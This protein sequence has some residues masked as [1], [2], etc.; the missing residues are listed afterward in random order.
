LRVQVL[1]CAEGNDD[2]YGGH[3]GTE[4]TVLDLGVGVLHAEASLPP[5]HGNGS[6]GE[7]AGGGGTGGVVTP[8][9]SGGT[10]GGGGVVAV[11][12]PTSTGGG[13]LPVTGP[14]A[15]LFAVGA[16][17]LVLIGRLLMV[18]AKR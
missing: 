7:D 15:T 14:G 8:P 4:Q 2:G 6:G 10:A 13:S 16:T 9:A 12:N 1:T 3:A 17:A 18:L 11:S 5:G